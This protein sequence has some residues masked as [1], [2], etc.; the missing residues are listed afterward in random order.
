MRRFSE[1]ILAFVIGSVLGAALYRPTRV[2]ASGGSVSVK[3]VNLYS[4]HE[5]INGNTVVG[6]SCTPSDCYI[7]SQ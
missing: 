2:S 1:I 5:S 7:A 4:T 3:R 6:F